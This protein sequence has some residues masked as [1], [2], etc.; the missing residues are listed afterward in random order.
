[1]NSPR[2]L[3]T[4][5]VA[6]SAPS[7]S[8]RRSGVAILSRKFWVSNMARPVRGP[9]EDAYDFL[10]YRLLK[11]SIRP[12]VSISFCLPVK[13]GWQFEQMSTPKSPRVENVS[14]TVPPAQ[15][16]RAGGWGG[17]RAWFFLAYFLGVT[18]A[19]PAVPGDPDSFGCPG[20]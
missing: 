8:W 2:L 13:N 11:R 17:W 10:A 7:S 6:S 4:S 1:M 9:T 16:L 12:A 3:I 15:L 5:A 20:P 19:V 14:W 18:A